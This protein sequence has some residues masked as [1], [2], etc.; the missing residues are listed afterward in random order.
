MNMT[1]YSNELVVLLNFTQSLCVRVEHFNWTLVSETGHILN[2]SV[3]D[4]PGDALYLQAKSFQLG[5]CGRENISL[6][7]CS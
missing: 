2:S 7:V 6:A 1:P 5:F 4:D 3:N